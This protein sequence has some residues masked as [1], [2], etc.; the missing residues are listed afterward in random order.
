VQHEGVRKFAAGQVVTPDDLAAV[1]SDNLGTQ[2]TA[3]AVVDDELDLSDFPPLSPDSTYD[4]A[5]DTYIAN[6]TR[7]NGK[8]SAGRH[9]MTASE[10]CAD[11][12]DMPCDNGAHDDGEMEPSEGGSCEEEMETA[13]ETCEVAVPPRPSPNHQRR[14][15]SQKQPVT[16]DAAQKLIVPTGVLPQPWVTGNPPNNP[17]GKQGIYRG[18]DIWPAN[19]RDRP[20]FQNLMQMI[21]SQRDP[22]S[23]APDSR[24]A[25]SYLSS[26][27]TDILSKWLV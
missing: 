12:Q 24:Y 17:E 23:K 25:R 3:S 18:Q 13:E 9:I 26:L 19:W 22:Y 10:E 1:L 8:A 20:A 21:N 16:K 4:E 5:I 2:P 15:I 27:L 7:A 14:H 11:S 6:A